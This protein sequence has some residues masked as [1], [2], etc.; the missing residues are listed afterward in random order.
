MELDDCISKDCSTIYRFQF[1]SI[2]FI[3]G[4]Y[5]PFTFH[6][7]IWSLYVQPFTPINCSTSKT[8]PNIGWN[9]NVSQ[10]SLPSLMVNNQNRSDCCGCAGLLASGSAADRQLFALC[11]E[12]FG[13][14]HDIDARQP[15]ILDEVSLA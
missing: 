13:S 2:A 10:R 1:A 9:N 8:L 7:N 6:S 14:V 3:C 5:L 12:W 11:Q 4:V 15:T